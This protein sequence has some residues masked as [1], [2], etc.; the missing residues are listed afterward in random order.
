MLWFI[1]GVYHFCWYTLYC[2]K[3]KKK[4]V[5][6]CTRPTD[7]MFEADPN[8]FFFHFHFFSQNSHPKNPKT[9][10]EKTKNAVKDAIKY[11][12][13][14][15][16][17]AVFRV[18]HRRPAVT[19]PHLRR[20]V[21]HIQ[22]ERRVNLDCGECDCI[23]HIFTSTVGVRLYDVFLSTRNKHKCF[24]KICVVFE[25]IYVLIHLNKYY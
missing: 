16:W 6:G 7:P 1:L 10:T 9:Y 4:K 24:Y 21:Q 15:R 18:W 14:H 11:R 17:P 5:F 22:Y 20:W 19:S 25:T 2:D 8:V 13:W 12:V 23:R 3:A